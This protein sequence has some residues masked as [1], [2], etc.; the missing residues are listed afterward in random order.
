MVRQLIILGLSFC[1]GFP[2]ALAKPPTTSTYVVPS[3]KD[4]K[5]NE[6]EKENGPDKKEIL[7]LTNLDTSP[8]IASP[9]QPFLYHLPLRPSVTLAVSRDYNFN[10]DT[11]GGWVGAHVAPWVKP[12]SRLQI[13]VD[14]YKTFGW[15]QLAYHHMPTRNYTR[16]YWGGGASVMVDSKDELRPFLR[17]KSYYIFGTAGWEFQLLDT[18][19]I[20]VE[21]SLHQSFQD[22]MFKLSLGYTVLL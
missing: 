6:S 21:G 1:S 19:N 5:R 7:E 12:T 10:K 4:E 16:F 11:S 13:G 9:P 22:T 20:R 14:I 15:L 18:Q 2:L 8:T 3:P 17:L